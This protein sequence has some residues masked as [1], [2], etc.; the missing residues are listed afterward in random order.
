MKSVWIIGGGHF[1]LRAAELLSGKDFRMEITVIEKAKKVCE[2]I[3]GMTF[4]TVCMDGITYLDNNLKTQE[5][6]DWIIPAIPVH[7]SYEWIRIKLLKNH[8]LAP[9]EV[10]DALI[11]NLPNPFK[12]ENSEIYISNADFICPDNCPEPDKICTYTGKPRP[13]SLYE[14]L[15]S[16]RYDDFLSIVIQ[17][18][19]LFPGLGGYTPKALFKALEEITALK[20]AVILSTACRCHGVM[21]VFRLE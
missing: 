18:R 21:N 7:V 2:Q 12:G 15:A 11:K 19:Q 8:R 10:P 5:Y 1:G 4:K 6:P 14:T 13:K 16:I 20:T 17:S 3:K 9:I